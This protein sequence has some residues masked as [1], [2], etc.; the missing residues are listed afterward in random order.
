MLIFFSGQTQVISHASNRIIKYN[1][2]FEPPA[3]FKFEIQNS[4]LDVLE[5][6][7]FNLNVGITGKELPKNVYV[8]YNGLSF[9]MLK[10]RTNIFSYNFK[11]IEE[12]ISF[13]LFSEKV[14]SKKF[15][16]TVLPLP[17]LKKMEVT[18]FAPKHTKIPKQSFEDI[19][20]L[21][22][23]EGSIIKWSFKSKNSDQ[24]AF[25][26]NDSSFVLTPDSLGESAIQ[27][28]IFNPSKYSISTSNEF[29]SFADSLH[30]NIDVTK[31]E[32]PVISIEEVFDS[33]MSTKKS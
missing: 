11:S 28:Q 10:K 15:E 31:D 8:K 17:I 13:Q 9:K 3:P 2:H 20:V 19:G 6:T 27:Q 29:L 12:D 7:N 16:I 24:I 25:F 14:N 23:P 26:I 5:K 33:I 18:V 22:V 4:T 32:Y 21:Q 30:Y 1:T